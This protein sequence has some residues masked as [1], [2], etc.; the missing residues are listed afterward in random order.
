MG[1]KSTFCS[2][3]HKNLFFLQS[4]YVMYVPKMFSLMF[5]VKLGLI[6]HQGLL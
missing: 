2:H 5:V 3:T 1:M 4:N 6:H